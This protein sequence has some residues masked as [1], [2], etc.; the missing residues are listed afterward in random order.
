MVKD[1]IMCRINAAISAAPYADQIQRISL[2]GSYAYGIPTEESDIDLL[3][4]FVTDNTIDIFEMVRLQNYFEK[5]L[6]KKVDLLTPDS[7]SKYIRHEVI[8]HAQPIYEIR[9]PILATHT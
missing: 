5:I 6:G 9:S 7:V 4:E 1:Q 3:I 8:A 2:F